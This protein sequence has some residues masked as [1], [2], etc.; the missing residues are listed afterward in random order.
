MV[1][2]VEN[3]AEISGTLLCVAAVPER[4]GFVGLSI[5]VEAAYAIGD[6]PNL[7]ER[8]IGEIVEVL[9]REDS[10]VAIAKPGPVKLRVKKGGP[11]TIFAE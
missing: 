10:A 4:P 3:H 7:F 8:N 9:A 2:I 5:K 11:T 6:W 1:Q